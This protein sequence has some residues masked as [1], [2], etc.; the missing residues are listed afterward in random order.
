MTDRG[1]TLYP[2]Q[3]SGWSF[4][5]NKFKMVTGLV[6]F[7]AVGLLHFTEDL[8]LHSMEPVDQSR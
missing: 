8:Y 1:P 6:F 7:V 5:M 3:I 2:S 4:G